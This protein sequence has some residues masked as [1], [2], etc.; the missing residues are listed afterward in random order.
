V[1]E[2]AFQRK[3]DLIL[4]QEPYIFKK[5]SVFYSIPYPAFDLILLGTGIRPGV[6]IYTRKKL[7]F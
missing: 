2:I 6:S 5:E 4:I 3:T 7:N 1:L